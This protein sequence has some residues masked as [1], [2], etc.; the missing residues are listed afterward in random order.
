[1]R[2][3]GRPAILKKQKNVFTDLLSNQAPLGS[4]HGCVVRL[5]C[6]DLL[7]SV[8]AWK[9]ID[10]LMGLNVRSMSFKDIMGCEL[11]PFFQLL[12]FW[13]ARFFLLLTFCAVHICL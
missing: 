4:A 7:C 10:V 3:M 8:A 6:F 9:R 5:N 1:M 12:V 13:H 2:H 11:Q